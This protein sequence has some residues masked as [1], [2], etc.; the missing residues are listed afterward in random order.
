MTSSDNSPFTPLAQHIFACLNW[1]DDTLNIDQIVA[2]VR[3]LPDNYSYSEQRDA[4]GDV[5]GALKALHSAGFIDYDHTGWAADILWNDYDW[6]RIRDE[7][8]F[9]APPLRKDA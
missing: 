2:E 4:F 8:T 1:A 9:V 3:P 5:A 6:H 7:R